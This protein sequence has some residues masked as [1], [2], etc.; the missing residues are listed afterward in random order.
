MSREIPAVPRGANGDGLI[1]HINDRLRRISS[2]LGTGAAGKAGAAGAA[3]TA[4]T[5]GPTALTPHLVP[6]VTATATP[7]ARQPVNV[8]KLT[9][10][11]TILKLPTGVPT[12]GTGLI[13]TLIVQQDATGGRT[14]DVSAYTSIPYALSTAQSPAT[15]ECI[16]VFYSDVT[17]TRALYPP[18][19][20][21]L[22]P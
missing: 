12:D 7:M 21:V 22:I 5:G 6:I 2:E 11:T 1:T 10:A 20:D 8:V 15:T 9:V 18:Q 13:W 17:G 4:G 14:L 16:Q 3:G 19:I